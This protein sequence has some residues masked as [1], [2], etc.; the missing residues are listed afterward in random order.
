MR[1]D[2]EPVGIG[3]AV[4]EDGWTGV[5][6]M[7][8]IRTARR[9]GVG[10]LALS[11]IAQ[12]GEANDAPHLYLQVEQSNVAARRLYPAAGFTEPAEY[13]YRCR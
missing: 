8:T 6:T 9:R 4:A 2:G 10:G 3:R 12:W 1:A 11:A 5:F 13:H 7:A